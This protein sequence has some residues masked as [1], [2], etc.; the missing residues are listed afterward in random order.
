[1]NDTD[2]SNHLDLGAV[3]G[4]GVSFGEKLDKLLGD[5][6]PQ[7]YSR[8]LL[9]VS[10]AANGFAQWRETPRFDKVWVV[11]FVAVWGAFPAP[12]TGS[13]V[14]YIGNNGSATPPAAEAIC[15][16]LGAAAVPNFQDFASDMVLA[17][18]GENAYVVSSAAENLRGV[19]IVTEY[20]RDTYNPS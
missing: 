19:M 10:D 14:F 16:L 4:I 1:M 18:P 12:P 6:P 13:V 5:K 11:R 20:D 3:A 17:Q 2:D 15:N 9:A 8:K 7:A